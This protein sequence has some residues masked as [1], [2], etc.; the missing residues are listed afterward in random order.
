[1]TAIGVRPNVDFCDKGDMVDLQRDIEGA[2]LVN[3]RQQTSYSDIFAAGDC[4]SVRAISENRGKEDGYD[5][6]WFQ[7]KLWTQARTMGHYAAQCMHE[8][9]HKSSTILG[10]I[11][12]TDV[13]NDI[14][15]EVFAHVTRFFGHKVVLLGR[16][17][18][19]GLGSNYEARVKDMVVTDKGLVD[20]ATS[21]AISQG[22]SNI[23]GTYAA[24]TDQVSSTLNDLEVW[25]RVTPGE[26]YVKVVVF[27]G[28]VV[29][30]LLLGDTDLEECMENL[31]LNRINITDIGAALLDPELDLEDYFD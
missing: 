2:L 20:S 28:R 17:N 10:D 16:Y 14:V 25:I 23:K 18:A 27:R 9:K 4:C 24:D 7:M 6:H 12:A 11:G 15:F 13:A 1:V 8:H 31:I 21:A 30:A 19:Q 3:N 22:K 5:C 29:G 26:E